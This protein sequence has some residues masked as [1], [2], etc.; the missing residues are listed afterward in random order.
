MK[1]HF[2]PDFVADSLRR[3]SVFFSPVWWRAFQP[4]RTRIS[5]R[6][7][8]RLVIGALVGIFLTGLLCHLIGGDGLQRLPWLVAPL[9][10]SAVLVFALPASPMAQPWAV[11]GGNTLSALVGI[12]GGCMAFICWAR[13]SW[14]LRWPSRRRLR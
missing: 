5:T 1:F 12:V 6:E 13:P 2:A 3:L 7:R 10:A 9:G 4:A 14:L 8:L 11:V